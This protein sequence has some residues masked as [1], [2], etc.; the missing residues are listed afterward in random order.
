MGVHGYAAIFINSNYI[1][2]NCVNVGLCVCV[3]VCV[4]VCGCGCG[5][6]CL[7]VCVCNATDVCGKAGPSKLSEERVH[8]HMNPRKTSL[9]MVKDF[10]S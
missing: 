6:G 2:L 9:K 8:P 7:F 1:V 10:V 4:C 5:C 3:C